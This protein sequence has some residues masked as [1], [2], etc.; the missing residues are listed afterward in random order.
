MGPGGRQT[1]F[2][3]PLPMQPHALDTC[4]HALRLCCTSGPFS[5][6]MAG[7]CWQVPSQLP[8]QSSCPRACNQSDLVPES[9]PEAPSEKRE[10]A[11]QHRDELGIP[12]VQFLANREPALPLAQGSNAAGHSGKPKVQMSTPCGLL[13]PDNASTVPLTPCVPNHTT[14]THLQTGGVCPS[15][16]LLAPVVGM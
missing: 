3:S 4:M 8:F 9:L 5:T 2:S 10:L 14:P 16:A 6:P 7:Q 12:C 13:T 1:R 15:C 11:Q